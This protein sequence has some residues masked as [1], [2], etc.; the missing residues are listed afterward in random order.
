MLRA[1]VQ[2]GLIVVNTHGAIADGTTVEISV[3]QVG[4]GKKKSGAAKSTKKKK[5]SKP[6]HA[7]GYGIWADRSELGSPEE[8]VDRL[9]A[10]TRR[11]RVG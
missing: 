10:K 1:I 2:D 5:S 9:R 4:T 6:S 8:A 11:H 3:A 7:P